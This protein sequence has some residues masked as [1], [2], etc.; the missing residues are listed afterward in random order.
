MGPSL[1]SVIHPPLVSSLPLGPSSP[2]SLTLV[3]SFTLFL[4]PWHHSGLSMDNLRAFW[5][6][7]SLFFFFASNF[8][9]YFFPFPHQPFLNFHS[10]KWV[11]VIT[12]CFWSLI[13]YLLFFEVAHSLNIFFSDHGEKACVWLSYFSQFDPDPSTLSFSCQPSHLLSLLSSQLLSG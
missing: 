12:F 3:N 10:L 9:D 6:S 13:F 4:K 5:F 2:K 7:L 1:T 11:F 8:Q